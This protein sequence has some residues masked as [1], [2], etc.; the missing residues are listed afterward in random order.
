MRVVV[1]VVV[2]VVVV[3]III[4]RISNRG[5]PTRGGPPT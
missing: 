3:I 2:V 5:Q 1:F 4:I